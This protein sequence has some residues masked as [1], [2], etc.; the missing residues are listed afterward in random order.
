MFSGNEASQPLL[1]TQIETMSKGFSFVQEHG[2]SSN[3][4][5]ARRNVQQIQHK[6]SP[7]PFV[8]RK[9]PRL[10]AQKNVLPEKV[11]DTKVEDEVLSSSCDGK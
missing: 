5:I 10:S 3:T 7:Q 11:P 4:P 2:L 8:K 1:D 6:T 9:S